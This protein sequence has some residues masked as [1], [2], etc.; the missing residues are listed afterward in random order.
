MKHLILITLLALSINI[1][2]AKDG[3]QSETNKSID[4]SKQDNNWFNLDW[5]ADKVYG[6]STEK[7]YSLLLK[8]KDSQQVIVAVIDAGV[9]VTH[10][11]LLNKIWVNDDEIPNNGIDDDNNGYID[12][13]N[14]WNYLGNTKGENIKYETLEATRLYVKYKNQIDSFIDTS[15][16]WGKYL[17]QIETEYNNKREEAVSNYNWFKNYDSVYIANDSLIIS[18]L[19]KESYTLSDLKKI[20]SNNHELIKAKKYMIRLY[21]RGFNIEKY[22]DYKEYV[23]TRYFYHTNIEYN[24]RLIAG[25]NPEDIN[26]T[27][28]GN[29][30]VTAN[31]PSHGTFVAGVIAADRTNSIGIKGIANNVKIMALRVV[32]DGDERDKDIARAIRYAADNGAKVINMSFGKAFS[33]QKQWVDDAVKYA[34]SKGLLFVHAAGNAAIDLDTAKNFP[35]KTDSSGTIITNNWINVG[36]SCY[37]ANKYLVATFSNYG[38]MNVDVFAPGH[39]MY[40]L[41]EENKYDSG[42]GTSYASPVVAGIAALIWSYYPNL[43]ANQIKEIILKSSTLPNN[44]KV[45]KPNLTRKK[46]TKINFSELS[47]TGGVVNVYSAFLLAESYK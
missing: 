32:N 13:I 11:D 19:A 38:K 23:N 46:N 4:L 3:K 15:S 41:K 27:N 26:D 18:Y 28:Y 7:A 22:N 34:T 44:L 2:F 33:P 31:T 29:N 43:S 45:Y 8:N 6:V 12:D 14:G 35:C 5:K 20:S 21:K 42:S 25:D 9:D 30:N 24:G 40:S 39:D 16:S 10:E 36:A 1:S 37:K 47:V 17:K